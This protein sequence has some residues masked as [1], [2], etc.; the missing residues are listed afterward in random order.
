MYSDI[1]ESSL[2]LSPFI[3]F[4]WIL[5]LFILLIFFLFVLILVVSRW[6]IFKK[7]GYEGWEAFIPFYSSWT[8]IKITGL[9]WWFFLI[10]NATF[11]AG[12]LSLGILAPLAGIATLI[13]TYFANYNL[14]IKFDKDPIAF[15]LGLTFLP[16]I[17]YPILAFGKSTYRDASVSIYGPLSDDTVYNFTENKKQPNKDGKFCKSCGNQVDDSKFCSKCGEKIR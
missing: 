15:G 6:K 4:A 8:L 3:G 14:S 2:N 5:L 9:E 10:V 12:V 13:G 1:W 16:F 17:F 7:A 11:F